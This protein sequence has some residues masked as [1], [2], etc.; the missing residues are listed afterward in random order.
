MKQ[1][2]MGFYGLFFTALIAFF[3]IDLLRHHDDL[4]L[5]FSWL[6]I[7]LNFAFCAIIAVGQKA[8]EKLNDL[9]SLYT[10]YLIKKTEALDKEGIK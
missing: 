10:N 1:D 3:G 5:V 9:Y 2:R 4:A 6:N 8:F 7:S